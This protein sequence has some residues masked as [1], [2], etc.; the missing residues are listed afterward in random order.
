M[1]DNRIMA[2]LIITF[3]VDDYLN[4]YNKSSLEF[5][6][7]V[8]PV[9]SNKISVSEPYKNYT[10]Q[11]K[12]TSFNVN[13]CFDEMNLSKKLKS[14]DF[15]ILKDKME[16]VLEGWGKKYKQQHERK[17]KEQERQ[18]KEHKKQVDLEHKESREFQAKQLNQEA[19]ER[20][21]A[22]NNILSQALL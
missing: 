18:F 21:E 11:G 17:F 16:T 5:C 20:I 8:P 15:F 3:D 6:Y 7:N 22:L 13:L 2:T 10:N 12:I 9:L 4:G 14:T 1:G 19:K